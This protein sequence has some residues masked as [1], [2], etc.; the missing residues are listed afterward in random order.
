M[1]QIRTS[2]S[3]T[4]MTPDDEGR[5]F[6]RSLE[7]DA[8]LRHVVP[9]GAHT[10]AKGDDQFPEGLAP[11]LVRGRGCRVVDVDGNEYIEYGMGLRA[12]VLGHGRAGGGRCRGPPGRAR[13]ELHP[14]GHDRARGR[15]GLPRLCTG[16]DMVKFTKDGSTANTAALR[17][18]RAATGRDIVAICAEHPFF[19]YDDWFIATTPCA[20]G[21]P[22]ASRRRD[23]NLPVQRPGTLERF[24]DRAPGR[25]PAS[26]SSRSGPTPRDGFSKRSGGCATHDGA[27]LV[28]DEKVTGFRWHVGGAPGDSRRHARPVDLRQGDGE[29]V[30]AVGARRQARA[31]GAA[32]VCEHEDDRVF[33]LSTTHGAEH[34]GARRGDRD[35]RR[36]PLPSP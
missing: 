16:A 26:C 13:H 25:S 15:R 23:R 28:F 35:H 31:D 18:A 1:R 27:V 6:R 21:I 32:V 2:A 33:L 17:L 20:A 11:V 12:V 19:S 36:L 9:G 8:R 34:T 5:M 4:S 29:R 22:T 10:Y 7:L 14:P 24:F 3:M 30:R